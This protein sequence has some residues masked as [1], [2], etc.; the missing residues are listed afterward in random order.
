[1][2]N[3]V[4]RI[5][6]DDVDSL[7]TEYFINICGFNKEGPK[8]KKLLDMGMSIK[9]KMKNSLDIKAIVS[10][11]SKDIISGNTVNINGVTF[12][13]N[14]FEQ[15]DYNSIKNIYAYILTAGIYELDN[16]DPIMNQLYEDI[17]G[18]SFVDAGLE[19][20]KKTLDQT[21]V[22]DDFGPGYYGMEI[23]Q[24][25]NFFQILDGEKIGVQVK[26]NSLMLPLKSLTGFIVSVEDESKLPAS[27]CKSCKAGNKGCS[28]CQAVMKGKR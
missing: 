8:Y 25:G 18:T 23:T 17:W 16:E 27:D 10:S 19:V 22:M 14:A 24:V 15:I 11:F 6:I 4:I 2:N 1:M 28:F 26:N 12:K 3:Q 7:A 5:N 13:C 9:E 20:L 21:N